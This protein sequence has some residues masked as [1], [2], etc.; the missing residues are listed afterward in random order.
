MY[1]TGQGREIAALRE[2]ITRLCAAMQY[3]NAS[4]DPD[5]VLRDILKS[6]S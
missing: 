4:L 1:T 3:I 2:R 6:A 5:T